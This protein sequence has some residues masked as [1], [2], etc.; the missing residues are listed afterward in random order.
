MGLYFFKVTQVPR[1]D[2]LAPKPFQLIL[3]SVLYD[4]EFEMVSSSAPLLTVVQVGT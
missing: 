2:S 4:P 3:R 1:T